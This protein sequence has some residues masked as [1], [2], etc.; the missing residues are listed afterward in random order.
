MSIGS[1]R[2]QA[3]IVNI[4]GKKAIRVDAELAGIL[5]LKYLVVFVV[6]LPILG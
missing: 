4:A 3:S 5:H 6:I 1:M 2:N